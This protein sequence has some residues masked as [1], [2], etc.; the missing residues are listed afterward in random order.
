MTFVGGPE[1]PFV[2]SPKTNYEKQAHCMQ[3]RNYLK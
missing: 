2:P 3:Q 1:F